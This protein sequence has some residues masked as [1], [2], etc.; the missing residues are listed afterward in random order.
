M[1][2][3]G[4]PLLARRSLG[5]M[6]SEVGLVD[7][8]SV[9]WPGRGRRDSAPPAIDEGVVFVAS[10]GH[11]FAPSFVAFFSGFDLGASANVGTI[12]KHFTVGVLGPAP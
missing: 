5:V 2:V 3:A 1:L 7:S 9:N 4:C 8:A 11:A 10:F 12:A 6:G